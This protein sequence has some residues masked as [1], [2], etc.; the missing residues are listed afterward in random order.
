MGVSGQLNHWR[1]YCAGRIS[2]TVVEGR[3]LSGLSGQIGEVENLF[4]LSRIELKF[5]LLSVRGLVT[6][7]T[8][9]FL[10]SL[11]V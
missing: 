2:D 9:L 5:L 7:L 10:Y 11:K 4:P 1:F 8:E 3:W 6:I